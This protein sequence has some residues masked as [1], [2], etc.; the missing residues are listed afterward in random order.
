MPNGGNGISL[1]G[2]TF[3][4]VIGPGNVISGNTLNGI[5]ASA[6]PVFLPNFVIGN[7]IGMPTA[8]GTHIGNQQSGIVVDSAP[9]TSVAHFNPTSTALIIG[10][11]NIIGDNQGSNNNPLNP[12]VL[13]SPNAGIVITGSSKGVKVT[14]NRIGLAQFVPLLP[15][16]YGN[17]GDGITVT[18]SGNSISGNTVA[19]NGRHGIVISGPATQSNSITGNTIGGD[20]ASASV[21]TLGN[22]SDGIHIDGASSTTIGGPGDT[23]FNTV[24]GNGRNGIKIRNGG[25]SGDVGNGWGNL[26]QRNLVYHNATAAVPIPLHAGIG[27]DLDQIEDAADDPSIPE[28]LTNTANLGQA[29]PIICM[30][31]A[32]PG[33]C[34]GSVPPTSSAGT[35]SLQWTITT[36]GPANFRVEFF[37]IDTADDNT[38]TKI[39]FLG[40]D[41][42]STGLSGL[43]VDSAECSAGRCTSSLAANLGGGYVLMTATDI[44][45]LIDMPGGTLDWKGALTCFAGDLGILLSECNVN[46][47]SEF[48]AVAQIPAAAPTVVTTTTDQRHGGCCDIAGQRERQ[49]RRC[50]RVVRIRLHHELWHD[51]RRHAVDP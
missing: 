3:A 46:N 51:H 22:T 40:E 9:D 49:R 24:V 4:N 10:P 31:P 8:D 39:T 11:A 42:F 43:P 7:I 32:D 21:L 12:D 48:S 37:Q 41:L 23:D 18:T 15:L 47:T 16:S 45:P 30:G 28:N 5:N 17:K 13:G 35:T 20:P 25:T 36:H 27:I 1:G 44:T 2:S 14:G 19:A 50:D 34:A 33:N 26:S 38:A 6:G 29:H